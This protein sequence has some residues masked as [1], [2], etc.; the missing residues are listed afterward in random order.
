MDGK[1]G[2]GFFGG[3]RAGMFLLG[4]SLALGFAFSAYMLSNA[5]VRMRQESLIRVKG[6]AQKH[7]TSNYATWSCAYSSRAGDLPSAYA[8]LE[9]AGKAVKDFLLA[10]KVAGGEMS[11]GPAGIEIQHKKDNK[12]NETNAI[13]G[14]VLR[15]CVTV[16]SSE[17]GKVDAVSKD[18]SSLIKSGIELQVNTPLFTYTDIEAVKLDLIAQATQSAYQRASIMAEN[19]HGKIAR[20]NSASQGVFQITSVNSTETSGEGCYDTSSIDKTVKCVVTL[21]FQVEK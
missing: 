18:I 20:L 15:Q 3:Q 6:Q 16:N 17:V 8:A 7:I 10:A 9:T 5:L 1:N 4:T 11:L 21:D 2:T 14:Y 13:E 19:S 12:G